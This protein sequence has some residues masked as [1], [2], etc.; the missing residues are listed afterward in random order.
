MPVLDA[1]PQPFKI[2]K[3]RRPDRWRGLTS[4][5][6]GLLCPIAYFPLL[7]E[8]SIS[9]KLVVQVK[10]DETVRVILNPVQVFVSAWL[11]PKSAL[12]RFG[13]SMEVLNRSFTDT[14]ALPSFGTTPKWMAPMSAVAAG[15]GAVDKGI[16]I[17][18]VLG[19]H[20]KTGSVI[21]SELAESYNR[22]INH[23]RSTVSKLLTPVQAWGTSLQPAFWNNERFAHIK[24]T[25]DAEQMEGA[26]PV[27]VV[28]NGVPLEAVDSG[29][30]LPTANTD[31]S[32]RSSVM[33]NG[34]VLTYGNQ[35]AISFDL[36]SDI[37][38]AA[39]TMSTAD[40]AVVRQTQAFAAIRDKYRN[41][42]EDYL[43]DMLMAGIRIPDSSFREP[44]LLGSATA[45]LGQH[46]RY[47]T[48]GASLDQSVS[49]M[50]SVLTLNISSP[51]VNPGGVVMVL[52]SVVPEQLFERR[53][54]PFLTVKGNGAA[55]DQGLPDYVSDYLDP[56][57]VEMVKNGDMDVLHTSP[58]GLFGYEPLNAKWMRQQ[59]RVGGRF[60]R[61]V[62]DAFVE[63]RARIW[64][65]DAVDPTLGTSF[66]VC[67]KPFP[68][69]VFADTSVDPYEVFVVGDM[70]ITG[71][72]VL[73]VPFNEDYQSYDEIIASV[74]RGRLE[75]DGT[76]VPS[77]LE[78]ET[79]EVVSH[80]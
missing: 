67:P 35:G 7:R 52:L 39:L 43:V 46:Q 13:G 70:V 65:V 57:K 77:V 44:I 64:A 19:V 62:P 27:Q 10:S 71:N 73:G 37:S 38:L 2:Q 17:Y 15:P 23:M 47:A 51:A 80:A 78:A 22:V 42:P 24:P 40:L 11:V 26:V 21:S 75:G 32:L 18:D 49:N 5:N 14:A 69:T 41:V 45:V 3:S 28:G 60:K 59:T 74:D 56:Q 30:G 4:V 50:Q 61:P 53:D 79:D 9:G 68:K 31:I 55:A 34:K 63:D 54:D 33:S 16:E 25:F 29:L 72:T 6:P 12:D 36:K 8:D 58:T 66:Y 20:Y 1:A 48:D 76:D